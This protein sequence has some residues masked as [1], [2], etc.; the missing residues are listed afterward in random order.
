MMYVA[1]I[2]ELTKYEI[3]EM[4]ARAEVIIDRK[5]LDNTTPNCG[6]LK[7]R[8]HNLLELLYL[9]NW[10]ALLRQMWYLTTLNQE[11]AQ[12]KPACRK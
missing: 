9:T 10:G 7:H 5:L 11:R 8:P 4:G 2:V 12:Q 1:V 6:D 3:D